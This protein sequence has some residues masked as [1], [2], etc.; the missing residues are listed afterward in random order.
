MTAEQFAA[1]TGIVTSLIFS[2]FPIIKDW[3][4]GQAPNVK[5]L[6]QVAVAFI[7]SWAIYG[8]NCAGVLT[9][10]TCDLAGALEVVWLIVAFVVANQA[11][12]AVSVR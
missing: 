10:M 5:R 1:I 2:Y 9:G 3:F 6:M 4:E 12:Y 7:V 11:A 8:L